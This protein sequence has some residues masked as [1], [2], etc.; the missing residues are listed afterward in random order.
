MTP[1]ATT[2]R[3][4]RTI[5]GRALPQTAARRASL[6]NL[7]SSHARLSSSRFS[8]TWL[9][10]LVLL[11]APAL[12]D[13]CA[14][15]CAMPMP[16]HGGSHAA[17]HGPA[18]GAVHAPAHDGHCGASSTRT[19]VAQAS[20]THASE[21][22]PSSPASPACA[23]STTA[24]QEETRPSHGDANGGDATHPTAIAAPRVV[25]DAGAMPLL[26]PSTHG[27][28]LHAR[29]GAPVSNG[30]R[31]AT[32]RAGGSDTER[33]AATVAT[34]ATATRVMFSAARSG[35]LDTLAQPLS[36][37]APLPLHRPLRV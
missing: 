25:V 2:P 7:R 31:S 32:V 23:A 4:P 20:V 33:A 18:S 16:A 14:A 21:T 36:R 5:P 29:T 30:T 34:A 12:T 6:A 8:I 11:L 15:M 1:H 3:T 37:P 9:L 13:V 17:G 27:C 26:Q 28:L 35:T 19:H 22:S 24:P 10:A